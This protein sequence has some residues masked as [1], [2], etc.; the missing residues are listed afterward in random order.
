MKS[1]VSKW[2]HENLRPLAADSDVSVP[3]WLSKTNY[4]EARKSELLR[5]H[6]KFE[7]NLD[8]NSVK[9]SKLCR[10]K[11]FVKD[12]T[13]PQYKYPRAIN[14]RSDAFKVRVGPIFKLIEA[15][16]FSL[17]WFIKHTP[18]D[19]RAQ[20]IKREVTQPNA[21]VVGTDYTSYEAM[22]TKEVMEIEFMLYEYMTQYLLD[23]DWLAIVKHAMTSTNKCSFKFFDLWIEATRMSGEMCTSLGNSFYNL[24]AFLFTAHRCGLTSV[25]GRVE[26]DDGIFS[27]YGRQLLPSDFEPLGAIIKIVEYESVTTGSFC[28][29]IA[30]EDE[31]INIREPIAALLDFGYVGQRYAFASDTTLCKLLRAKAMSLISQYNGCPILTS[32]ASYA[33]RMTEGFELKFAY[34]ASTYV[35]KR[36]RSMIERF[37]GAIEPGLNTRILMEERFKI[38]MSVQIE[39]ENY[40]DGLTELQPLNHPAILAYCNSEQKDYY[41]KY[42]TDTSHGRIPYFGD[43]YCRN[44]YKGYD[45]VLDVI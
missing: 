19:M 12:E 21:R 38:P 20:E 15:A 44:K 39:I 5:E 27:Y 22:F 11:S 28:G 25:K 9:Y 2:M 3:T 33:L 29:V 24:M 34:S 45:F 14:S 6:L 7:G 1:F 8:R 26:G 10:V 17:P 16:V 42:S 18:S 40:L 30:D 4:N 36:A 41:S 35:E 43:S 13:Y 32:L 23:K 31:M 37:Q